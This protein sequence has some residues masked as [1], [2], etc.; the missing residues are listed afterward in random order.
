M[1]HSVAEGLKLNVFYFISQVY[2]VDFYFSEISSNRQE[3]RRPYVK[4]LICNSLCFLGKNV[5]TH[6]SPFP[7]MCFRS[8]R[9]SYVSIDKK[10]WNN[11]QHVR[12]GRHY[13]ALYPCRVCTL[14]WPPIV[15]RGKKVALWCAKWFTDLEDINK[16]FI[17]DS[18]QE[19]PSN[20]KQR[21]WKNNSLR[22]IP[23]LSLIFS[24]SM[25]SVVQ[26]AA[27]ELEQI[28]FFPFSLECLPLCRC[29]DTC[30][31][32]ISE[33]FH[34]LG[35]KHWVKVLTVCLWRK[36]TGCCFMSG[37]NVWWLMAS[38]YSSLD[39]PLWCWHFS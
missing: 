1:L 39:N 10:S 9:L 34:I 12:R 7:F 11:C 36:L 6:L 4:R 15:V 25:S 33:L 30:D 38:N 37:V 18:E 22:L 35:P 31:H 21:L 14:A 26:M 13:L 23:L 17:Q 2:G 29:H 3:T 32:F 19:V 27:L 28:L 24:R 5:H 8:Y 20:F 16:L